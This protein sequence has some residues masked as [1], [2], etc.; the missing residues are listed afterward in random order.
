MKTEDD[1]HKHKCTK[2]QK[3]ISNKGLKHFENIQS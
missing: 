3:L 2:S 1:K